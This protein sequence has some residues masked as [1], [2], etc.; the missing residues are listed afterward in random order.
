MILDNFEQNHYLKISIRCDWGIKGEG[1]LVTLKS[2]LTPK[3]W[4]TISDFQ[5]NQ[6]CLN[7]I[8]I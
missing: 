2:L 4:I 3:K 1:G 5:S 6:P 8:E 7:F